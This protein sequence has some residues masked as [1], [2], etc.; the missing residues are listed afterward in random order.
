[1]LR[2]YPLG[3]PAI[4]RQIQGLLVALRSLFRS[5]K[6]LHMGLLEGALFFEEHLF[7]QSQPA[8]EELA[9]TLKS[10]ALKGLEFHPGLTAKELQILLDL[11]DRK[12]A[13]GEALED[14]LAERGVHNIRPLA[15]EDEDETADDPPRKVY[16]RALQVMEKIFH[17]VRLGKNPTSDDAVKVVKSMVQLTLSEP[18]ALFALSMLK[19]YD[20]YTFTH[21]VNVAVIALTLGRACD[22]T[23]ERLRTLGLGSLLHDL[24]KLH[25]DRDI[26]TKPGKL[27]EEEFALIRQHP[28]LGA[29]IVGEMEGVPPE[30]MDIVLGHHL[31]FDGQGYPV[32]ARGRTVSPLVELAAIAD[33]YDAITTFRSYQRPMTPR[34]AIQRLRE[35][36]G[37]VL[38]P[39]YVKRFIASLGSYPVGSLV[40]LDSNEIGVVVRV[41]EKDP[42]A[43]TLTVLFDPGGKQIASPRRMDLNGTD[44]VRI[45]AEVDPFVRGI[46]VT[47]YFD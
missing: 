30:A 18:H 28:R 6:V 12:E 20:N 7:A 5:Q 41:G 24:G 27:T 39:G 16:G 47:D 40:R 25:I 37:T 44:A 2:L 23:P 14:A 34:Q 11:L 1:M 38:N 33:T 21:S 22:L 19:D 4:E 31:R 45:V 43:V 46:E 35:V 13:R 32:E 26:I 42:D 29:D 15:D 8:A 9:R 17:D 3:H 36:S 10:L